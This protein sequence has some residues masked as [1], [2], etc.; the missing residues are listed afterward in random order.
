MKKTFI[1]EEKKDLRNIFRRL[2]KRD[3]S[4]N[5][6]LFMKNSAYQFGTTFFAKIGSLIFTIILARL[7]MPELFGLYSLALSTLI[8]FIGLTDLGLE[9]GMVFFLSK[10][11]SKKNKSKAKSY[12]IYLS[13]A[14]LWVLLVVISILLLLSRTIS[15]SYYQ[16]PIFAAL[17]IGALYVFFRSIVS[18]SKAIFYSLNNFKQPFIWEISFQILRL[19]IVPL[20]IILFL[21]TIKND[22]SKIS[23]I[24]FALALSWF[25]VFGMII[26]SFF[27]SIDFLKISHKKLQKRD[28]QGIKKMIMPLSAITLSG[29]FFGYIDM[30]VLGRFVLAEYIGYYQVAFSLVGSIAALIT[31]STVLLP[32]F[33]RMKGKQLENAAKRAI[34]GTS[35]LASL[36]LIA[37]FIFAPLLVK[38]VFGADYSNAIPLL[39][40]LSLLILVLPLNVIYNSK[41]ISQGK[42][43]II[44]K[45][46]ILTTIVNISLNYFVA[47]SLI[48]QGPMAIVYGICFTTI[49]S[50]YLY[51]AALSIASR[52]K[53]SK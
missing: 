24:I 41:L 21:D 1:Q 49:F 7:L 37:T 4:G 48:S 20:V 13:K 18:F 3:F 9:S 35:I 12:L 30:F 40:I 46:L 15:V 45:L 34:K 44:A 26:R 29:I 38:I 39:R 5:M 47:I 2:L 53:K 8:L 52:K 42:P 14:K 43:A 50:K 27:T 11:L 25:L 17:I 19:I 28:K 31:F 33:S 23:I 36:V 16:K 32:I 6:G 22:P 51:L 10:V